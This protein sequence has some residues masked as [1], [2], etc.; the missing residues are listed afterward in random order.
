MAILRTY[1]GVS[2]ESFFCDY[3]CVGFFLKGKVEPKQVSINARFVLVYSFRL[4]F[5]SKFSLYHFAIVQYQGYGC[6]GPHA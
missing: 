5:G 2:V 3:Q 1:I 6:E 4:N